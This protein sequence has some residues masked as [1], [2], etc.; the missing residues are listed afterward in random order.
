MQNVAHF[1]GRVGMC[2]GIADSIK[3]L[4]SGNVQREGGVQTIIE[5]LLSFDEGDYMDK[6]YSELGF[7]TTR[8]E[9]TND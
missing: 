6:V 7:K 9:K 3:H 2:M 5:V 4:P 8:N 1:F